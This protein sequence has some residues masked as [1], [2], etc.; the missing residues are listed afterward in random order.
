MVNNSRERD[1]QTGYGITNPGAH[2]RLRECFAIY[3]PLR[4]ILDRHRV[5]QE[6]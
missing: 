2:Y 1:D 6:G 3:R 5:E 4:M